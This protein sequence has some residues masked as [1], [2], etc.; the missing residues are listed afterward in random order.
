MMSRDLLSRQ[1]GPE[2]VLRC[3]CRDIASHLM[4]GRTPKCP[5]CGGKTT[6]LFGDSWEQ[7]K[8]EN[9]R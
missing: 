1:Y 2:I 5:N 9:K 3:G 4:D 6:I 8:Q 7:I